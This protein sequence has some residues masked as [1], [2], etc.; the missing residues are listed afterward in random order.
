MLRTLFGLLLIAL[1]SLAQSGGTASLVGN[2]SDPSGAVVAGVKVTARNLGTQ[3]V[4]EGETNATGAYYIPNLPSGNY[5][6]VVE[7]QGFKR[8]VQSGI[9]LRINEQPR[10]D[11]QLQVGNVTESV[12]VS[13]APPLLE[14]ESAGNGQILDSEL[15]TRLP[16][17]QKFVHRV[18][19]YMPGMTNINGQHAAGQ[20]QRALG[21]TMD[22]VNGKEPAVGQVGDFQRTMIASLDSIQEFKMWTTGTPAEFGHSGGGLLSVV[23]KGGT[24]QWHGSFEDRYT[25]G[26]L[27]HRSYLEQLP[28]TGDFIY[29]EW[30]AT[31]SGPI[32]KDKTFFFFGF[33]QHYEKLNETFI[34]SVPSPEM[35]N[36]NFSFNGQGFP[37]YNPFTTRQEAGVWVRDPFPGNQIPQSM[38]DPAARKLIDLKPWRAQT[39]PGIITPTGP[40][41][42]LTISAFGG[43]V[44]SRY[45]GK[46]DH[47]FTTNHK[48][49]G[50]YSLVRH[51]SEER[52]VRELSEVVY[53]NVYVK[54]VDFTNIVVTDSYTFNPTTINEIRLGFNRRVF[55]AVPESYNQDW[56]GK[57]GIPN[58]S[59]ATFPEFR[60]PNGARFY[61]LGPDGKSSQVSE[62]FTFQENF[63]KVHDR[64][65][66]KAGY[67]LIRTRYTSL[68]TA[69]P[70]GEYR[71]GG[72]EF[73]FR[74]NTGNA[75]ASL[76]LGTVVQGIYTENA[77]T[78]LPRWWQHA[79]YFQDTWRPM[80]NLT[81]ELGLRW[82]YESPFSTKWGQQSQFDPTVRDPLTGRQGAIVHGTGNLAKRD[83]NN[84]QPRLG[85]AWTFTPKTV[86]RGSFGMF[87]IDLM[88]NGVNQNFEEYLATA[89]VQA[90]PGD[91]RHSF[92][93]AQGPPRINYPV[94][95]DGSVPFQGTNFG[96]RNA[97]WFDPGMRLPYTYMWSAGIQ[98]QL[99]GTWLVEG[100]YQGSAGVGLLNNWDTN[101]VPL[102]ISNNPVVLNQVFQAVQNYKPYTQFGQ[103]QHFSNYGHN[104][105]HSGMLR[106]ERRFAQ[107]MTLNAF[108]QLGKTINNSDNDGGMNGITFY[109]RALEKA[110]A[111]YDIRHRFV[112]MLTYELPFGKG[113]KW[114]NG[115]GIS[116]WV[117]GNWDFAWT[118]TFQSGP[119][120]TV[121]F[122]GS[123]NRYLPGV[124][125]P[126]QI[127]PNDQAQPQPWD[128][129]PNRFPLS[130]QN[131]YYSFDGFAYPAAFTPGT[132]GRNTFESPGLRWTQLS[133]SKEF[134]IKERFIF[135]IRWDVNNPT[136]EPQFPDPNGVFNLANRATFG[137]FA[138]NGRGSFSDIGTSR[139]HHIIVGRF[140][141]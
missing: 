51:R 112:G 118:Q 30:G 10:I 89:N 61:N 136:K 53:G 97:S 109:N 19:L 15:V 58:V 103:I 16:V 50:R 84:F 35:M 135:S 33:Q 27:I 96:G 67:E 130:A 115:G 98:H 62:D 55:S 4:Y 7:S 82:T 46:I 131:R 138:G 12:Q 105:H 47:Q 44:F 86:F 56:A 72:T 66:F 40:T 114:M 57:L 140:Q 48:L 101:V 6:I 104:T 39:D 129:G 117:F 137:T 37:I 5:E 64:H 102:D 24:N 79:L 141:F 132:L 70:S 116:D 25:N 17:M 125:R 42:N 120:T 9:T 36:G 90:P 69:Q 75:F 91:P 88:T 113:R 3:F 100:L 63:T 23:F 2:V 45:D 21:Y 76:L 108:Y 1:P 32:R 14:T 133:I 123:P 124:S 60:Q 99:S 110:R 111:N 119:P 128:V 41:N 107:G 77:A 106:F 54:P 43:Y 92:R 68:P 127:L 126:N 74:P 59:P 93:L 65:T 87:A 29:Q 22:G 122:A 13:A 81:L 71:M 11:V 38:F 83:L 26:K 94:A 85:V 28:R 139:M 31:A 80:R 134:K 34:G 20:R 52:P 18:L 121:T 78:W 95:P 73:P 49:N 8:F